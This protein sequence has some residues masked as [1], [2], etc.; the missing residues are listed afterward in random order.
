[1]S[2]IWELLRPI[3][4]LCDKKQPTKALAGLE[5]LWAKFPKPQTR[6]KN[7]YLVV[8]YGVILC[9]ETGDLEC[10]KKW[11]E[12]A[13]LYS[14]NFNLAGGSEFLFAEVAFAR[15]EKEIAEDYFKAAKKMGG[16][17]Q[18]KDKNPKYLELA[19]REKR[20]KK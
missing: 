4:E 11:A 3:D 8:S 2:D 1:M 12:R 19:K 5:R 16:V 15:G 20:K 14:G 6:A 17:R 9:L 7:S 18:F 13:L 10:A